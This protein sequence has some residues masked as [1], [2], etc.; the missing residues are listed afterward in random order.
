MTDKTFE[1]IESQ[2]VDQIIKQPEY[3]VNINGENKNETTKMTDFDVKKFNLD[4]DVDKAL[5]KKIAREKEKKKL[6]SLEKPEIKKKIYELSVGEIL[7][8][9]K[10]TWFDILDDLLQYKFSLDIFIKGNR[11]FFIGLTIAIIVLII[12]LYELLTNN[13]DENKDEN[14]DDTNNKVK[15]IHHIYHVVKQN[16]ENKNDN[17]IIT[18][19]IMSTLSNHENKSD[20]ITKQIMSTLSNHVGE[21]TDVQNNNTK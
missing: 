1:Q 8:G 16:D 3:D 13:D 12:Y 10:D 14:K 20:N 17:N 11:L 6:A 15:E 19:Q 2:D 7:I 18:K 9:I 4:F 21:L 5:Q